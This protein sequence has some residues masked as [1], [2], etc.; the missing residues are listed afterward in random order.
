M[1]SPPALAE[2]AF[3]AML[4]IAR[5]GACGM[6]LPG[7]GEAEIPA[8][9]RVGLVLALVPLLLPGA[10]PTLPPAP[11]SAAGTVLL[12]AGE[13]AIGIWLGMLARLVST[14]L[15]MAGQ[16]IGSFIGLSAIFAPDPTMGAQGT[17]LSRMMS[18]AAAALAL[19]SGLYAL[20]LR[21]LAESYTVLPAGALLGGDFAA[22]AM[23]EA[24]AANLALALRLAAPLLLLALLVQ[25]ATGLLSRVAPQAQVFILAAPAQ[26][27][28]GLGLLALLLPALFAQWQESARAAWSL[29]PGLR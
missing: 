15:A 25:A 26:T 14:A 18:I 12:L 29:L 8:P 16:M 7:T 17:A 10:M 13:M 11:D 21:A 24:G 28:V 5:I 2:I 22:A 4:I 3:A 20:P 9:I 27:L 23:A 1:E 19:S 6:L